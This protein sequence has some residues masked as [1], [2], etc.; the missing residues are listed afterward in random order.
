MSG[1]RTNR[2]LYHVPLAS[3]LRRQELPAVMAGD[4]DVEDHPRLHGRR[5]ACPGEML[6][7]AELGRFDQHLAPGANLRLEVT[8]QRRLSFFA[9]PASTV[10]DDLASNL[11]HARGRGT[12]P[13]RE[14]KHVKMSEPACVDEIER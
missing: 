1:S 6:G 12:G 10:L 7:A 3:V 11:R 9:Q 14:R 5:E 2:G 8:A 13:E 4:G